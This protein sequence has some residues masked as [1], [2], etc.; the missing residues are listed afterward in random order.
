[1]AHRNKNTENAVNK[2]KSLDTDVLGNP[3]D[4]PGNG[5]GNGATVTL[6]NPITESTRDDEGLLTVKTTTK[7]EGEIDEPSKEAKERFSNLSK[8][9]QKKVTDKYLADKK[10]VES[11]KIISQVPIRGAMKIKAGP[12]IKDVKLREFPPGS[13]S[14]PPPDESTTKKIKFKSSKHKSNLKSVKHKKIKGT[15]IASCSGD[16]CKPFENKPIDDHFSD[17]SI[18]EAKQKRINKRAR[19]KAGLGSGSGQQKRH[20]NK[21]PLKIRLH[22][23]FNK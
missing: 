16:E 22:R 21:I 3:T 17:K 10:A 19:K 23:M 2:W 9:E 8:E 11:S 12:D 13:I 4:P 18:S 20:K 1:M 7:G 15:G 14:G 5:N 6:E